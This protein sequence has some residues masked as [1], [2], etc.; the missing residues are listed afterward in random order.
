MSSMLPGQLASAPRTTNSKTKIQK[1]YKKG[2]VTFLI[3]CQDAAGSK[4]SMVSGR[5]FFINNLLNGGPRIKT[6]YLALDTGAP[7][8]V[9]AVDPEHSVAF[10][11]DDR[12]T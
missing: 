7:G 8:S 6:R 12:K 10:F 9:L 1:K 4:D 3:L 2:L 5:I 11:D